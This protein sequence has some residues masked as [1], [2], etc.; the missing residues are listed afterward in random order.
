MKEFTLIKKMIK[1]E[2]VFFW[3]IILGFTGSVLAEKKLIVTAEA[4][5]SVFEASPDR[6]P[7]RKTEHLLSA[8]IGRGVKEGKFISYLKFDLSEIPDS[9]LFHYISIDSTKLSL[10]AQSFGLADS[11][12]MFFVTINSCSDTS[13]D[14]TKMNW[15]SRVCTDSMEGED[16]RVIHGRDLPRIYS[17]D[18]TR[19]I[20]NARDTDDSKIT[21]IVDSFLLHRG[22]GAREIVRGER[23]GPEDSVG[24][25]RFWSRERVKFGINAVPTL[26]IK[27][28]SHPTAFLKFLNSTGAILSAIG[29]VAGL[30]EF[31]RR[32]KN[33]KKV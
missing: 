7:T 9:T 16:S 33:K 3:I 32:K 27:Y 8:G 5:V 19:S 18:I 12:E 25:V 13:W 20:E 29:V 11:D 28:S 14:E 31:F 22:E 26:T 23:F 2:Y 6:V 15:N 1:I 10:L 24:F 4:D 17:W 21:F 30:Y